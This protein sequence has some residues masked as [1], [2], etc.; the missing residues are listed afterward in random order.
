MKG[1]PEIAK[2]MISC[3]LLIRLRIEKHQSSAV[4]QEAL[5]HT[6]YTLQL[7]FLDHPRT[8]NLL[9]LIKKTQITAKVPSKNEDSSLI[10]DEREN[11]LDNQWLLFT[12]NSSACNV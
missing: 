7:F 8:K 4:G 11:G 12:V 6:I 3:F 5:L 9:K 10:A 2:L 1:N